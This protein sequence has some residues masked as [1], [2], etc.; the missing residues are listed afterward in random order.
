MH[1]SH[2]LLVGYSP[3]LCPFC[4]LANAGWTGSCDENRPLPTLWHQCMPAAAF[5][6]G[7]AAPVHAAGSHAALLAAQP[8]SVLFQPVSTGKK[9]KIEDEV[10]ILDDDDDDDYD[11]DD[12]SERLR[13]RRDEQLQ[14]FAAAQLAHVNASIATFIVP[15]SSDWE[16][17]S[18]FLRMWRWLAHA[19]PTFP[20]SPEG[21]VLKLAQHADRHPTFEFHD[22]GSMTLHL[23]SG[24]CGECHNELAR[25]VRSARACM[26]GSS[27]A[28]CVLRVFGVGVVAVALGLLCT[29][30]VAPAQRALCRA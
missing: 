8:S 12:E 11:D 24:C 28:G 7:G 22:D 15:G 1:V 29:Q 21:R 10:I 5:A 18:R 25:C 4:T 14:R 16:R 2:K 3:R 9:Y 26:R 6:V 19:Q 27:Q 20:M 17:R 30:R 23:G 13:A